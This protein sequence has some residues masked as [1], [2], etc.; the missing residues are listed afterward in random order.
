MI[1]RERQ[2]P[3][4]VDAIAVGCPTIP[5]QGMVGGGGCCT[6]T[7]GGRGPREG[8]RMRVRCRIGSTACR[9][10]EKGKRLE[11]PGSRRNPSGERTLWS[12]TMAW[13]QV[14]QVAAKA[15]VVAG[16]TGRA[17]AQVG[18]RRQRESTLRP[19]AAGNLPT[20]SSRVPFARQKPHTSRSG[21]PL[22]WQGTKPGKTPSVPS[23]S[24][25]TASEKR[26]F[27]FTHYVRSVDLWRK[28]G[29]PSGW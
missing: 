13:R 28:R 17:D 6:Q 24:C 29:E 2:F 19:S 1:V 23:E 7:G 14:D 22:F 8:S 9:G 3:Y 25:M 5:R 15:A 27:R 20:E 18:M 16:I 21:S 10:R 12:L 26:L 11:G 4:Q